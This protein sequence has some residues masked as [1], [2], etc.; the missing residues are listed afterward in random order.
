[1]DLLNATKFIIGLVFLCVGAYQDIKER[2]ISAILWLFMGILASVI[3]FLI[4][5]NDIFY[6]VVFILIFFLWF[7]DLK[8][9][10]KFVDFAFLI[11]LVLILIFTK[12]GL[13]FF[14]DGILMIVYKNFYNFGIIGGKAD[15]RAIMAITMLNPL[16]PEL[17]TSFY[18]NRELVSV[19]FPYSLEVLFYAVILNA[20]IFSLYLFIANIKNG[21]ELKMKKIFTH[22]YRGNEWIK[23]QTPFIFSLLLA[24]ILSY[25]FDLF[26]FI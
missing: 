11:F 22:I 23:Y 10:E 9:Y 20:I 6:I 14:L 7:V 12:E 8:T 3:L 19:I 17:F 21:A 4:N 25:V 5:L 18:A 16:Y 15:A 24:F 1:M 13:A 2:E 26:C